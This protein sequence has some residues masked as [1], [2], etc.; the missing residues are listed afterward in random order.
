MTSFN[1]LDPTTDI[2]QNLL[3]EASAGCGKT[4]TIEHLIARLIKDGIPLEQ[5]VVVTFTKKGAADLKERIFANLKKESFGNRIDFDEANI[6]TIHAFVLKLL[7]EDPVSAGA[8]FETIASTELLHQQVL[9]FL[10]TTPEFMSIDE[11]EELLKEYPIKPLKNALINKTLEGYEELQIR[12]NDF[13]A[14]YKVREEVFE[15]DDIL[16]TFNHCLQNSEKLE[17]L[18]KRFRVGIIDEFQDTDPLQWEIFHKLFLHEKGRLYLVGDPKQSIYSFRKGD[19]YTYLEAQGLLGK[20]AH[21]ELSVNFRSDP[22]LIEGLNRLY[23]LAEGPSFLPLPRLNQHIPVPLVMSPP[24]KVDSPLFRSGEKSWEKIQFFHSDKG[25][26]AFFNFI[27]ARIYELSNQGVLLS[28]MA[29]LVDTNDLGYQFQN[30]LKQHKIPSKLQRDTREELSE[31]EK[32]LKKIIQAVE[33]PKNDAWLLT[34]LCTPFFGW[35]SSDKEKFKDLLYK[36]KIV[37]IFLQLKESLEAGEQPFFGALLSINWEGIS[38]K[39]RLLQLSDGEEWIEEIERVIKVVSTTDDETEIPATTTSENAVQILTLHVS[40]GLEFEVVFPLGVAMRRKKRKTKIEDPLKEKEESAE[41]LRL[42]YVA[43]TRAKKQ[44]FIPLNFKKKRS[45][46]LTPPIDLFLE[47]CFKK[48]D[49]E[50]LAAKGLAI[51]EASGNEV[52]PPFVKPALQTLVSPEIIDTSLP[53]K[54]LFSFTRLKG[55]QAKSPLDIEYDPTDLPPGAE[56]GV[57]F[58][59]LLEKI[60]LSL[61]K[62]ATSPA[63]L[64]DFTSHFTKGT[65][66]EMWQDLICQKL[67]NIYNSS[68]PGESFCLKEVDE[69]TS[70]REVEFLHQFNEGYMKGVIDWLFE[71]DGAFYIVDWKT[72]WLSDY[73][74]ESLRRTLVEEDYVLQAKIYEEAVQK[75]LSRFHLSGAIKGTYFYFI[76]GEKICRTN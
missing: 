46:L 39:E 54:E 29:V 42:L 3:L 1:I 18:Q 67:F 53:L 41:K 48:L 8:L 55:G 30:Y 24:D 9:D 64:F 76:R 12:F 57:M 16:K 70:F 7:K 20:D 5:M 60:P 32:A 50:T 58:H 66:W 51:V 2:H 56:T 38:I 36:E 61:V 28:N 15:Y 40:K 33:N 63:D 59:E 31:P 74:D 6:T 25:P 68:L 26:E 14:A 65:S 35:T 19:I 21:R 10:K 75:F 34:A 43:L 4:F 44:L 69:T 27:A 52:I 47:Q 73:E 62:E 17:L 11:I 23:Q 22:S 72:N 13:L 71:K 49:V 37:W 45:D